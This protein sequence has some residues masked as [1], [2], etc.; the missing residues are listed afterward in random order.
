EPDSVLSAVSST[1]GIQDEPGNPLVEQIARH[2]KQADTLLMLDNFEHV[3]TAAERLDDLLNAC[4]RLTIVVTG[5]ATLNLS[6]EYELAIGE[7][8]REEAVT[9]FCLRAQQVKAS[10]TLDEKSRRSVEAICR[11]LDGIP[12]A[13]EL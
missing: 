6:T 2:L 1:L 8:T 13:V 11:H 5:R 9:L 10:F 12:L 7:L 3:L 4:Q